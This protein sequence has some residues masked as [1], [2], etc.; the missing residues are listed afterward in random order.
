VA[1]TVNNKVQ[2]LLNKYPGA[3][4][5]T[6]GHSLGGALATIA[7][8]ELRRVFY[9]VEVEIHHY[10][11]PRVGNVHL[12]KHITNKIP[13]IYRVVHHKDIVPHLPPDLPEFE[14]HHTAYEIFWDL[15]FT[16]YKT[17]DTSGEDKSC[18]NQF[19]PEYS[20]SDHDT[21]FIKMSSPKC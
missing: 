19:F 16:E 5:V 12:S 9:N 14:Y 11:A 17:C 21:Y 8:L 20:T 4:V 2:T 3:R 10:G 6:T 7:G 1:A 13:N 18:S 15:D